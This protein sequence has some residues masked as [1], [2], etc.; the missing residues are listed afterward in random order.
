MAEIAGLGKCG[1]C[2]DDI[3]DKRTGVPSAIRHLRGHQLAHKACADKQAA[4]ELTHE[5]QIEQA[6]AAVADATNK[7]NVATYN[8]QV[9]QTKLA[10][11]QASVE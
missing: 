9:A 10:Q 5:Y 2:Y 7:L 8:L 3:Q 6:E 4:Y 11:L 1:I